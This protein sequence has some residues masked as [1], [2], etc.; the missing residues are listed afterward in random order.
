ME[1]IE[2]I[3]HKNVKYIPIWREANPYDDLGLNKIIRNVAGMVCIE[4]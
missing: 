3:A 1:V 4:K 2:D